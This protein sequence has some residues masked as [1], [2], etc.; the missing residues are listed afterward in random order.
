MERRRRKYQTERQLAL[1][2]SI[3]GGVVVLL[4]FIAILVTSGSS[5]ESGAAARPPVVRRHVV[6]AVE[7][8]PKAPFAEQADEGEEPEEPPKPRPRKRRRRNGPLYGKAL[9]EAINNAYLAARRRA[10]RYAKE[11]RW[12]KAID[13]MEKVTDHF[14]DHELRLRAQPDIDDFR[15]QAKAAYLAKTREAE[16]L[17]D[18]GQFQKA[19]KI[20]LG[21]AD[22]FGIE[23][24][25][26]KARG[27]AQKLAERKVEAEE[28]HYARSLEPIEQAILAWDF[29]GAL[30]RASRLRFEGAKYRQRLAVRVQR[31]GELVAMKKK[32]IAAVNTAMPRLRKRDL[33]AP[34][35]KGD[36]V[37]ANPRFILAESERG[38]ERIPWI[39]FGREGALRLALVA[40][41]KDDASH[42]LA[43][44]RLLIEVGYFRRAKQQLA[45]AKRLGAQTDADEAELERRVQDAKG[46]EQ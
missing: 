26:E 14:D 24:Y 4:I 21:I 44:A 1:A 3:G 40:G 8:A 15:E 33:R 35:L 46:E 32:M 30:A 19:R 9:R 20:V 23:S 37:E 6:P 42:R 13:A 38:Q 16:Q 12:G 28:A 10:K 17:A 36:L 22:T 41:E 39:K 34:G 43:V 25:V 7:P 31:I 27:R 5:N 18:A 11:G 29:E 2:L 45:Q